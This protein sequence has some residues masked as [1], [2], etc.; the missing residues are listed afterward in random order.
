MNPDRAREILPAL[1]QGAEILIIRLRSLGDMVMIT[2]ALEM[3]HAWRPD[4]RLCVLAEPAHAPVLEQNPAVAEILIHRRFADTARVLRR[5]RFA[6]TYNQHGGPTSALLTMAAG[7]PLRVCWQHCQFAAAYNVRVPDGPPELAEGNRT[8]RPRIHTVE[9]RMLQFFATGL[10]RAPIPRPRVYVRE[11]EIR[12]VRQKLSEA[13]LAPG[14]AY[15]VLHPGGA[16]F[17]KRWPL[18]RFAAVADFLHADYATRSL[19]VL[20]PGDAHLA[21][22]VAAHSRS[23]A[24]VLQGLPLRELIA[25]IAGA[26]VFVGNDSGPA[27]LA[28]AAG[29]PV[30][31]IFGSSDSLVWRP[32]Q[33][34]HRVVQNEL[35]CNPCKGDRCYAF[36]EPQCILSITLQQVADACDALLAD[37][38]S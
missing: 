37:K 7:S 6:V 34:V 26:R 30:A 25:L 17:T 13:G 2:P 4:L 10:P 21:A 15:A 19:V 27:H 18:E 1:P 14:A 12:A 38:K 5:R 35:A 33:T 9:H 31:V 16:Y 22:E 28:T 20:G 36:A 23:F 8:S 11:D 3:L 24:V 29:T 32:W